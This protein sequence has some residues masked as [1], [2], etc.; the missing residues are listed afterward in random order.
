MI[1]RRNLFATIITITG[2]LLAGTSTAAAAQPERADVWDQGGLTVL[3][4][5]GAQLV[6]QQN[7]ISMS[8][9]MP[10]PEPGSYLY[11]VGT[12]MGHPEV[13]T[14]WAFVFNYPENC[15]GGCGGDDMSNPAVGF[16]AYNPGGHV[17]SGAVL[18]LAGRVGVGDPA[19]GPPGSA[20]TDLS[21]PMGAEVHLAVTSHGGLDPST[22]PDEFR[23]P[24]GNG[25]CGC[26]WVAIFD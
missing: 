15:V 18:N 13:F 7:G 21:N 19:G 25:G 1:M 10:A 11:P 24:T 17:N 3:A 9:A 6:R 26:W 2:L 12:E 4:Q 22:L 16:G 23:I 8:F 14:L 20:V 5:D